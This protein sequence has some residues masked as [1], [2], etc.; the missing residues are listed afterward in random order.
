MR[1][2]ILLGLMAVGLAGCGL[3]ECK[4]TEPPPPPPPTPYAALSGELQL[5]RIKDELRVIGLA[6]QKYA[7][8][9][10]G[11]L[12]PR[13]AHLVAQGY[14]PSGALI[15]SADPSGGREGGVPDSYAEWGQAKEADEPGSSYL[16]EFNDAECQWDWKG[17]LG[18][19]PS[20]ADI[21]T[22]KDGKTTWAEVKAWHLQHGD[23]VQSPPGRTYPK[24]RF[25]LVRCYWFRYPDAY[26]DISIQ[27]TVNLAVDLETTFLAQPWWEKDSNVK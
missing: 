3:K 13:L 7:R 21:D 25:P 20:A 8:E 11:Q 10:N 23:T 2:V 4:V 27:S 22:N 14:L 6:L 19:N 5:E 1:R 26:S 9:H 17:Y 18:G 12:P 24:N 15:S 16:Y